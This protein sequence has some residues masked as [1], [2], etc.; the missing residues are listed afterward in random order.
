M[1]QS[2][3]ALVTDGRSTWGDEDLMYDA[4]E[5]EWRLVERVDIPRWPARHDFLA[6]YA[7]A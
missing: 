3:I 7:R 2:V 5:T 1:P 4:L 6:V